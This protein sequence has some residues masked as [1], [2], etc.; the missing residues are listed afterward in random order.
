MSGSTIRL[1]V[2]VDLELVSGPERDE[3]TVLD[4]FCHAIGEQNGAGEKA[5]KVTL[6]D[7]EF[8][9]PVSVYKVKLADDRP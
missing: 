8:D 1:R 5:V 4:A 7:A 9:P 6:G 2:Y 3:E